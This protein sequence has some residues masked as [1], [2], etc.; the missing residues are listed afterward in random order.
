MSHRAEIPTLNFRRVILSITIGLCTCLFSLTPNL[1]A[2]ETNQQTLDPPLTA[3]QVVSRMVEMSDLRTEALRGYTSLRTYHL[4]LHGVI[5]LR[6]DMEVKMTYRYPGVKEFTII[7]ESGSA[8]VRDH[9]FKRLLEAE[10]QASQ[11]DENRRVAITPE[12][13]DFELAGYERDGDGHDYI[14]KVTPRVK[15]KFLFQGFIWVNDQNFAIVRID[16]QPAKALSWWTTKVNFVYR[17]K[18]V[19][20]FWLPAL[21]E[22]VTNVRVFGRSLLTI[23]YKD[24]NLT[25]ALNVKS[26]VPLRPVSSNGAHNMILIPPSPARE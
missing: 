8:Y 13:Y 24:Y 21:N 14:L 6:A 11:K 10:N 22:T 16:G 18:R 4:E 19:G 12:N 9:V 15:K 7:S 20:E 2:A 1:R 26:A 23:Q 3:G 17:Y 25:E 5:H